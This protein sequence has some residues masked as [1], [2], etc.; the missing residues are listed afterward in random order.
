MQNSFFAPQLVLKQ[1]HKRAQKW[2]I[3]WLGSVEVNAS[4]LIGSFILDLIINPSAKSNLYG[5][6]TYEQINMITF[7]SPLKRN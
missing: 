5:N 6:S 2:P 3:I 7:S 1:R 4:I